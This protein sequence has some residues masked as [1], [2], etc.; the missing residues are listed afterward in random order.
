MGNHQDNSCPRVGNKTAGRG[1][2]PPG[3]E[4]LLPVFP[5]VY[6]GGTGD[7]TMFR[8]GGRDMR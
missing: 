6:F 2:P 5:F 4:A 3:L 8:T 1:K 7:G